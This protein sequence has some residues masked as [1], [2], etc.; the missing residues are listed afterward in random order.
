MVGRPTIQSSG[1]PRGFPTF[2]MTS[3][4]T[5]PNV[6]A[7]SMPDRGRPHQADR[8]APSG[9]LVPLHLPSAVAGASSSRTLPMVSR[10]PLQPLRRAVLAAVVA[11]ASAAIAGCGAGGEADSLDVV[12]VDPDVPADHDYLIPAGSGELIDAGEQLE[13]FP[14]TLQVHVGETIR[15]VNADDRGHLVGPFFIAARSTLT[16][17]FASEGRFIGTC[18]VHPSGDFVLDVV[19]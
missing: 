3:V 13:I 12:A 10:R 7:D 2:R 9:T 8:P 18:S 5:G 17:R 1:Y 6:P 14:L 19:A 15:I 11:A 4:T 16:Q